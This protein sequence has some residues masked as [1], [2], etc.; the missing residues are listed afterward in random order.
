[1]YSGRP[2]HWRFEEGEG[3]H[4]LHSWGLGDAGFV[5]WVPE[6]APRTV[7]PQID[8]A[9]R[10]ET[11]EDS[12]TTTAWNKTAG[13]GERNSQKLAIADRSA[14]SCADSLSVGEDQA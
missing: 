5:G 6:D 11:P 10:G 2:G 9:S 7:W 12:K 4:T 1:M 13:S 3:E 8:T 14:A